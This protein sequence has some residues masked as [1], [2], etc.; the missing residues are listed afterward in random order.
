MT[1]LHRELKQ[2]CLHGLCSNAGEGLHMDDTF[3]ITFG[4]TLC[5][6]TRTLVAVMYWDQWVANE[7]GAGH[8][9]QRPEN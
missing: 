5:H 7:M 2:H 9:A 4:T 3:L 1:I 6:G 8:E